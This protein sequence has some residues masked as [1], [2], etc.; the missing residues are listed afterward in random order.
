MGCTVV[1]AVTLIG[2]TAALTA[3]HL[4]P[5]AVAAWEVYVRDTETRIVRE[6]RSNKGFLVL[7]VGPDAVA[8]RRALAGGSLIVEPM[9]GAGFDAPAARVEHW[10]GAVFVRGMCAMRLVEEL[11]KGPPPSDDVLRSAVLDRGPDWMRVSMRLQRTAIVTAVYDTEH[12]VTFTRESA[13][14]ATSMSTAVRIAEVAEV[15]TPSEHQLPAG[16]D[17][18]F[19]WRLNAYWR[20]EDAPGGVIAEC[21]SITLSRDVPAVL[22]FVANPLIERTARES[23]SRTLTTLRTR[24]GR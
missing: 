9:S 11:E 23:M 14:R 2:S 1:I 24:F 5:D 8:E 20:Y 4:R 10:R 13:S 18:G 19:L 7:D 6:L 21:E 16:H 12:L 15:S 22:R 17:R 3:A